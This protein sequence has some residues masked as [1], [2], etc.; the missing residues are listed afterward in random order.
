MSTTTTRAARTA[1]S[2][3]GVVPL[4]ANCTADIAAK[5]TNARAVDVASS[6]H[7]TPGICDIRSAG[8]IEKTNR[9]T[10]RATSPHRAVG[11]V[12]CRVPMT[13]EG[14]VGTSPSPTVAIPSTVPATTAMSAHPRMTSTNPRTTRPHPYEPPLRVR[15]QV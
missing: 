11:N 3:R 6:P 1:L 10:A 14:R 15:G 4:S 7:R 5:A 12:A 9:A 2:S 13:G 8:R